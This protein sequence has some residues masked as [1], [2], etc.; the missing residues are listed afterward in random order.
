MSYESR[1]FVVEKSSAL[2]EMIGDTYKRWAQV[3]AVFNL[4][5]VPK[6]ASLFRKKGK[7]TDCFIYEHDGNTKIVEDE[8]GEPLF[9]L[10]LSD[11]IDCLK[12]IKE[13]EEYY[14]RINPCL[15]LLEGFKMSDWK[16][17]V[18]LHCGY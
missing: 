10:P 9:E 15:M 18:V 12:D 3:I 14:R 7:A 16:E 4:C 5:S 6:I 8:Y 13:N 11:V 2:G 17:L 1:L